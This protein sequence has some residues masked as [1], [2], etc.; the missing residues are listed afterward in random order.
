MKE[1]SHT[2]TYI[3]PPNLGAFLKIKSIKLGTEKKKE[4]LFRMKNECK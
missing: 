1:F 4:W 3:H 2:Y